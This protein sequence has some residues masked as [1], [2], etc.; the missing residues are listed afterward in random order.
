MLR[1]MGRARSHTQAT[2]SLC[3]FDAVLGARRGSKVA[4]AE[5]DRS[6][7]QL[8]TDS[9][10]AFNAHADSEEIDAWWRRKP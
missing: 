4:Q 9:L 5:R 2:S 8:R 10:I 1:W 3:D 6:E 7:Q